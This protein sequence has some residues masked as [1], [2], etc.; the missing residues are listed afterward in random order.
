MVWRAINLG[1]FINGMAQQ[2]LPEAFLGHEDEIDKFFR[3]CHDLV[4]K[5]L[6]LVGIGLEVSFP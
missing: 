1:H 4:L 6:V 2:P 5:L 3:S